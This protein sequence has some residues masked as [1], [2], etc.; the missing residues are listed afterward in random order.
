MLVVV[1]VVFGRTVVAL[2]KY[3]YSS[4]RSVLGRASVILFTC[5]VMM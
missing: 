2:N 5:N 1:V 3:G 4:L